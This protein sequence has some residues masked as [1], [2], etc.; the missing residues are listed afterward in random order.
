MR[1]Y[2]TMACANTVPHP[3]T[4]YDSSLEGLDAVYYANPS[5]SGKPVAFDYEPGTLD[6]D[7]NDTSP[8]AAVT[9]VDD[10]SARYTGRL[11]FP[12]GDYQLRATAEGGVRVWLDGVRVTEKWSIAAD[13]SQAGTVEFPASG[14]RDLKLRVEFLRGIRAWTGGTIMCEQVGNY[15]WHDRRLRALRMGRLK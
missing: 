8:H 14:M 12:A 13:T 11:V 4:I 10:W 5:L 3:Q 1:C 9:S 7:W 6:H 15:G 2:G